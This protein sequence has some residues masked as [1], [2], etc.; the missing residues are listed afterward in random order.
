MSHGQNLGSTSGEPESVAQQKGMDL[1]ESW[2]GL[3]M[4]DFSADGR[5][6]TFSNIPAAAAAGISKSLQLISSF[7]QDRA[8]GLYRQ[9]VYA[10]SGQLHCKEPIPP[11]I[12]NKYSQK[13]NC[14]AKISTF[15]CL[16]AIYILPRSICLFFCRKYVDRSWEYINR[17]KTQEFGNWD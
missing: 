3:K 1:L 17:S 6:H 5:L 14:A 13:R 8:Y 10:P 2:H 9:A 4:C 16:W 12:R 7:C 15:M 11:K